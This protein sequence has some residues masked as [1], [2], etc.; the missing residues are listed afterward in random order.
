MKL[1]IVTV[2]YNQARFLERAL[3]SVLSQ[4]VDD[5]EYIVVDA[6]STDGSRAIIETYR[7]RL[8]K[9]TLEPDRGPA[10]GLNKGFAN[11][12]GDVYA[13]VNA[14]D[15]LM[16]GAAHSAVTFLEEHREVDVVYGNGYI[17]D[18]TG[19]PIRRFRSS[20]FTPWRFA[21]GAAIV[22]QQAT[23]I[24]ADA[25]RRTSGFNIGNRTC[26]D[27]ELLV[28][29]ALAGARMRRVDEYWGLF[30]IH[31]AS[32]S[33]SQLL[34]TQYESDRR[35]L[36]RKMDGRIAH[37]RATV[38]NLA[39]RVLKWGTDPVGVAWRLADLVRPPRIGEAP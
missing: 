12:S 10:D 26:W 17:V 19:K 13:Y 34:G 15:A 6:G 24:R 20:G 16:P 27:A 31:N 5:L 4:D 9:V 28:D 14:D 22:M 3:T 25:F 33:G 37:K 8:T 39:G 7:D 21:H 1:S 2:S 30:T 36:L 32:I 18:M 23:F 11:A 38:A 29:L 35:E